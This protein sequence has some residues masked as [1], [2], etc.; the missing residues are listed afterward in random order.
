MRGQGDVDPVVDV[1]PFRV[2]VGLFG[3]DGHARHKAEG[4]VE[5]VEGKALED[6]VA[7]LDRGPAG[8]FGQQRGACLRRERGH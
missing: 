6:R 2:V 1:E 4:G 7:V 3:L 5:V 8:Q